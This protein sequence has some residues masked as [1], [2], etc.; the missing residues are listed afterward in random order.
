M[1]L[2]YTDEVKQVTQRVRRFMQQEVYPAEETYY[3]QDRA[4]PTC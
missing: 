2:E 1:D 4:R 3:E